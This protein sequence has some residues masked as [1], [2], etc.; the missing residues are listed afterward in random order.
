MKD[1]KGTKEER[2]RNAKL[3]LKKRNE[4]GNQKKNEEGTHCS[5]IQKLEFL[6]HKQMFLKSKLLE[7]KCW[8]FSGKTW[9]F[10]PQSFGGGR[11]WA[12]KIAT[13]FAGTFESILMDYETY[14]VHNL[15]VVVFSLRRS[16][17][18]SFCTWSHIFP[19]IGIFQKLATRTWVSF[20]VKILCICWLL[21]IY[22]VLKR[23]T[24]N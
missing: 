10:E 22:E 12:A 24:L 2:K 15:A 17:L 9:K 11:N 21:N 6:A 4:S 19:K 13:L 23:G 7:S 18:A 8:I 5:K 3:F 16:L 20:C 14:E 1:W